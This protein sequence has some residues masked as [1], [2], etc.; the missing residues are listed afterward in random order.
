MKTKDLEQ[1]LTEAGYEKNIVIIRKSTTYYYSKRYG[2][3]LVITSNGIPVIIED[4][5]YG[6]ISAKNISMIAKKGMSAP[7]I[8]K[9][10]MLYLH[11]ILKDIPEGFQGDHY[12]HNRFDCTDANIRI[13]DHWQN[14]K[15]KRKWLPVPKETEDGRYYF[16]G[17]IYCDM[18]T[19]NTLQDKGYKIVCTLNNRYCLESPHYEDM[20]LCCQEA[21]WFN[22]LRFGEFAYSPEDDFEDRMFDFEDG[23][24]GEGTELL[25]RHKILQE[26]TCEEMVA[27][28]K[29]RLANEKYNGVPLSYYMH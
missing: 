28:N 14:D 25:I 22:D 13:C 24:I 20:R 17:D 11:Q 8:Y 2:K 3:I 18:E 9:P 23:N 1:I 21:R 27:L 4:K 12:N 5:I 16:K 15:N 10:Q 26:I 6:D 7:C 29:K 19:W